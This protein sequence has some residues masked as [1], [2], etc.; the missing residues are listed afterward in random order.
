MKKNKKLILCLL[1]AAIMVISLFNVAGEHLFAV[2]VGHP[3][4]SDNIHDGEYGVLA[5]GHPTAYTLP[6][7]SSIIKNSDG[8]FCRIEAPSAFYGPDSVSG[9]QKMTDGVTVETYNSSFQCIDSKKLPAELDLYGGF[10]AN[11]NYNYIVYGQYNGSCSEDIE[12]FRVCQYDKQWNKTATASMKSSG[13]K[14]PFD[15]STVSACQLGDVIIFLTGCVDSVN[16]QGTCNFAFDESTGDFAKDYPLPGGSSHSFNQFVRMTPDNEITSISHADAGWVRGINLNLTHYDEQWEA[17]TGYECNLRPA[18]GKSGD[19]WTGMS[20]GGY[21]ISDKSY[22]VAFDDSGMGDSKKQE[23]RSLYIA[24]LPLDS[25]LNALEMKIDTSRLNVVTLAS[26]GTDS[27]ITA[28]TPQLVEITKDKYMVLWE[29]FDKTGMNYLSTE[30]YTSFG[31]DIQYKFD[32]SCPGHNKCYYAIVDGSGN[33]TQGRTEIAAAL[34]DCQPIADGDNVIWYVTQNSAPTFFT[35]NSSTGVLTTAGYSMADWKYIA[36]SDMPTQQET[37]GQEETSEEAVQTENTTASDKQNRSDN[38]SVVD[39]FTGLTVSVNGKEATVISVNQ[40][41]TDIT[42]PDTVRVKKKYYTVTAIGPNAFRDCSNLTKVLIPNSIQSI[43]KTAFAGCS[44]LKQS[45]ITLRS[46]TYLVSVQ[47]KKSKRAVVKWAKVALVNGYQLQY[48]TNK[49]LKHPKTK[50]IK[51]GR[52]N[53]SSKTLVNLKKGKKYY[54]RIR[55]YKN[56]SG[57][58]YYS[59]WSGKRNVSIKK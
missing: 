8:T 30:G 54:C 12:V 27:N 38:T 5:D 52:K 18:S 33:V 43:D 56:I 47:N 22:L 20:I 31:D 46:G 9:E 3:M 4:V 10:Y 40:S 24:S 19:N 29:E 42:I 2:D 53:P 39:R 36:P 15:A 16:H 49:K 37:T 21:E 17:N 26:Y 51:I 41:I 50:V 6:S 14:S 23:S 44:K 13:V 48:T 57:K 55:V 25:A 11:E 1:T 45:A 35:L 32:R 7:F 59:A 28:C 58:R 34:S